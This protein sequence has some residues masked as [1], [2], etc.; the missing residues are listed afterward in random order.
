M[1]A[2]T[3]IRDEPQILITLL[4]PDGGDWP[5]AAEEVDFLIPRRL[6]RVTG[7][8]QLNAIAFDWALERSD[9]RLVDAVTPTGYDRIVDVH[10]YSPDT[11]KT[12]R[13][14]WGKL[15]DQSH[16]L[17]ENTE[18]VRPSARI[19]PWL[20]GEQKTNG[21]FVRFDAST[22]Y[23]VDGPLVFNPEFDNRILGNRASE[24]LG[25]A[26]WWLDP[27]TARTPAAATRAGVT[28]QRWTLPQVVHT[29]CRMLNPLEPY[30]RNPDLT[31]L[32]AVL[33]STDVDAAELVRNVSLDSDLWLSECLDQVLEPLGFGWFLEFDDD[34]ATTGIDK[35]HTRFKF[36]KLGFGTQRK[37]FLQ[38]PGTEAISREKTNV[39]DY[40]ANISL[41]DLANQIEGF[42]SSL[43]VES[44][45]ELY[46]TWAIASDDDTQDELNT[47]EKRANGVVHRQYVLNEDGGINNV[48]TVPTTATDLDGILTEPHPVDGARVLPI[49]RRRFLP[50]LTEGLERGTTANNADSD[51]ELIGRSGFLL[52]YKQRH[53]DPINL[54]GDYDAS[55]NTPDLDTAPADIVKYD[56][57]TVSVAGTFFAT[58]VTPGDI[59][60]AQ[61]DD[62]T[63]EAHWLIVSG[64][65]GDPDYTSPNAGTWAP[66][67]W[68]F[69]VL[70]DRCGIRFT[71]P[72]RPELW[73]QLQNFPDDPPIRLT[74]SI[75]SDFAR[76][77]IATKQ[78][79]SPQADT[80]R[81]ILDL[82]SRFHVRR[83]DSTS[84]LYADRHPA[85][86]LTVAGSAPD[87][88][89]HVA[90]APVVP[91]QVG[92][93]FAVTGSTGNDG[94]YTVDDI[95][96]DTE[97]FTLETIPDATADGNLALFTREIDDTRELE[98]YLEHVRNW[99][100]SAELSVS[101]TLDAIDHAD[102]GLG[103]LITSV[104]GRNL[105]LDANSPSAGTARFPQVVGISLELQGATQKTELI[106]ESFKLERFSFEREA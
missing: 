70:D 28:A 39:A 25:T 60:V 56:T 32:E 106:L 48:R 12:R 9:D 58:A 87:A 75:E 104:E 84:T 34:V 35:L 82:S 45:F 99:D 1:A 29:L 54:L 78:A 63:V 18:A 93:R 73:T 13:L 64:D 65:V 51:R 67:D 98:A 69:E 76:H 40:H 17:N 59:L 68:P 71:G 96:G 89:F 20:I 3:T 8:G 11:G 92:D 81:S 101:V 21:Y 91:L 46:P 62:P 19:E 23:Q 27:E 36:Y 97:I 103:D 88:V 33:V 80:V 41:S 38:R 77:K 44:S 85:I 37:V 50:A 72:V 22:K 94:L 14:C 42:T 2:T 30:V 16:Y 10:A 74:C 4:G 24:L 7:G 90:A 100:D 79:S 15:G 105:S 57:Y 61:Q 102:Y 86:T 66:V 43:V 83:V 5:T 53:F 6:A 95:V 49:R 55:A 47:K 52:E 26:Y 31:D